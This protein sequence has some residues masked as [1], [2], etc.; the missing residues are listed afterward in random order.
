MRSLHYSSIV[1]LFVFF[2]MFLIEMTSD[3][4][5]TQCRADLEL[6]SYLKP[7]ILL[8]TYKPWGLHLHLSLF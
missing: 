3:K 8:T 7:R 5:Y 6:F 1:S 4:S 2:A